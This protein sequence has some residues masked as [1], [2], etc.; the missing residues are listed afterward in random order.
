MLLDAFGDASD[1][2]AW[3]AARAIENR[4]TVRQLRGQIDLKL[5]EHPL[6]RGGHG[7]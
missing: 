5:V 2:Y 1:L 6:Y 4:W 7:T 3:Y